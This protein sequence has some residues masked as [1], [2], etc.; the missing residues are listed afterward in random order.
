MKTNLIQ[1]IFLGVGIMT[2]VA[3]TFFSL[4]QKVDLPLENTIYVEDD[5]ETVKQFKVSELNLVPGYST[6]Y[7]Y[8]LLSNSGSDYNIQIEFI[9]QQLGDLENY[10]IVEIIAG[11]QTITKTLDLLLIEGLY[12]SKARTDKLVIIYKMSLDV[13]NEAQGKEVLFDIEVSVS[14]G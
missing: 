14:K 6:E 12:L 10:I 11:D 13:G 7:V 5:E 1:Y 8:T 4:N 2:I 3:G 9:N